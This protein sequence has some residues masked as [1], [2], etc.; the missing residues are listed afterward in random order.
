MQKGQV[1]SACFEK[2]LNSR[3][4][5]SFSV[6]AQVLQFNLLLPPPPP[7]HIRE[8]TQNACTEIDLQIDGF[9]RGLRF[10]KTKLIGRQATPDQGLYTFFEVMPLLFFFPPSKPQV[11]C[12]LSWVQDP[13]KRVVTKPEIERF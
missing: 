11:P 7:L 10:S 13:C 6:I 1:K 12:V 2:P 3:P 9:V 5:K 8:R 4:D